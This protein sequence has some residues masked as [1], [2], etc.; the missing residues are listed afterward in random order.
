MA[1][2]LVDKLKGNIEVET[3]LHQGSKFI[4]TLPI[5]D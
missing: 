3:E 5:K 2:K 4:I 1:K